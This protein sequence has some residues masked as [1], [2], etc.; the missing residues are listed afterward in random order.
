MAST[1]ADPEPEP[2]P[3]LGD[4][5]NGYVASTFEGDDPDDD[6]H[7]AAG[8]DPTAEDLPY[9]F[10]PAD[11]EV[12][13]ELIEQAYAENDNDF[14]RVHAIIEE[15]GRR[16]LAFEHPLVREVSWV[17]SYHLAWLDKGK[18]GTILSSTGFG[19][20]SWPP[21]PRS[22]A[23]AVVQ[24]MESLAD[25]LTHPAAVARVNDLLFEGRHGNGRD[26]AQRAAEAY[27][28][29]GSVRPVEVDQ[30]KA[31]AR[32]WTLARSVKLAD[33]D[34]AVRDQMAELALA[35]LPDFD[36]LP[37][38][39]VLPPLELLAQGPL[40]RTGTDP[41]DTDVLLAAAAQ[42]V[43]DG[44][45]ATVI[46]QL[47]RART[48]D[49]GDLAQIIDDELDGYFRR[50]DK[51]ADDGLARVFFLE[52][53]SRRARALGRPERAREAA[54]EL[55][56]AG[57]AVQYQRFRQKISM[58]RYIP[59]TYLS[60]FTQSADWRDGLR[61]FFETPV[62][63]KSLKTID[64]HAADP[65]GFLDAVTHVAMGG[66]GMPRATTDSPEDE[67]A[68]RRDRIAKTY[69]AHTGHLLAT[70]L[71]RMRA[72]YGVP[73]ES[74]IVAVVMEGG[75]SDPLLARS[76]AKA[77]RHYWASDYESSVHLAVP[78]V[79]AAMRNVLCELDEGIYRVEVGETPGGY[80]GMHVLLKHLEDLALDESWAY[81]LRWLFLGPFGANL[82]N[83]VAH[84]YVPDI[85]ASHTALALRA[86]AMLVT[87]SGPPTY[88]RL[89]DELGDP[90]LDESPP[91]TSVEIT[92]K[93]RFPLGEPGREDR[94]LGGVARA[95]ERA[96]WHVEVLRI[97]RRRLR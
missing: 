83:E 86:L 33:V 70:G 82:R 77:L 59:E 11:V 57:R 7:L 17:A 96:L 24:L 41:I 52:E 6:L 80:P 72:Q 22:V 34:T 32:A 46:A 88:D 84:G 65:V 48:T 91:R 63:T 45:D 64:E 66:H 13:A 20:A 42:V 15:A 16:G 56:Q 61:Y 95:L 94:L 69:A 26:R 50:A 47:R 21:D 90:P 31:L 53:A 37:A 39:L 27:V 2:D 92:D 9:S 8:K 71:D 44:D 79:E 85:S 23:P 36:D 51:R 54:A 49:Q 19:R 55:Q 68:S 4:D 5:V 43:A 40:D 35:A 38:G 87:V 29:L 97:R 75:A 67:L 25:R 73:D 58:P 74:Q 93:L 14:G 28:E 18:A 78:K 89:G 30:V 62:P 76:F 81:F 60:G 3:A 12:A 1:T 10:D